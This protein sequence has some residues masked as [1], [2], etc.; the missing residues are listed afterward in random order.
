M[1]NFEPNEDFSDDKAKSSQMMEGTANKK[2]IP[3]RQVE[4]CREDHSD[5]AEKG[6]A[7]DN[8][9]R[10][11][12]MRQSS[13]P[14]KSKLPPVCLRLETLSKKKNGNG[15]SR[16]P[17][18]PGLKRQSDEYVHKPSASSVLKESTPQGS[19]SAD[20][21]FKRRGDG[22]PKKTE[23]KALAVVDGKNC[24]NKNEHL[25]SGSH[26]EN[27][28]KLSTD[29]E[30]VTGK[31]SAV[32][33]GKDT[34]GC[35][36][37]QDKKATSEEKMAAEG[38]TEEDKLNDSAESVNGECMAKEKN[39]S[40]DQAA[41][42]I[43]SAYRGFEVRKLEPLKKLKQMVEV[44]DQAAEI[45]K[46]IQAL[47]SSSDLLKNEKERVLIGEMIMRTLLKLDTIQVYVYLILFCV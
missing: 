20:D 40:D 12:K 39:L 36:L 47:E 4:M 24:E 35:D 43:Q 28:I 18:P 17:S 44:R 3:V 10:T 30:D 46:R 8:S 9:S 19:Q 42:L 6:V 41:V 38:A 2:I 23:K 14:P 16:S 15:N 29:L 31:S 22:N 27:S 5:S 33:N 1:K 45:R 37:I 21:S 34:D 25:K 11:S 32:G 7:A 13:S 26:M